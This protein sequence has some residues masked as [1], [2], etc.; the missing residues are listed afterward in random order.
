MSDNRIGRMTEPTDELRRRKSANARRSDGLHVLY[1]HWGEGN[2]L[3]YVGIT[4]SPRRRNREHA[5]DKDWWHEVRATTYEHFV[6][7]DELIAAEAHAIRTEHPRYNRALRAYVCAACGGEVDPGTQRSPGERR[8]EPTPLRSPSVRRQPSG[9]R[10]PHILDDVRVVWPSGC[11]KAWSGDLVARLRQVFPGRYSGLDEMRLALALKPH[12][13]RPRQVKSGGINR[14][15]Y[16]REDFHR[17]VTELSL[18][19]NE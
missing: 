16:A 3:L 9:A 4:D 15:G 1:R 17:T 11:A 2:Q 6:S 5:S 18:A 13:V 7:R 8:P 19:V 12:G 10:D 14:Q